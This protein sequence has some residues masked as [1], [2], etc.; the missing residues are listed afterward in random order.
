MRGHSFAIVSNEY[1]DPQDPASLSEI[2]SLAADGSNSG[3]LIDNSE[4]VSMADGLEHQLEKQRLSP[5]STRAGEIS[6]SLM[7]LSE[8][9]I[10]KYMYGPYESVPKQ[11]ATS[12]ARGIVQAKHLVLPQILPRRI[13][14]FQLLSPG[15]KS[16]M[17]TG[18]GGNTEEEGRPSNAKKPSSEQEPKPASQSGEKKR[19][20]S[21]QRII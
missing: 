12:Q 2:L 4:V 19:V 5:S 18:K 16:K 1:L 15:N 9:E 3:N 11:Q 13:Q 14:T 7:Q 8:G 10:N 17:A 20:E 21:N 6:A